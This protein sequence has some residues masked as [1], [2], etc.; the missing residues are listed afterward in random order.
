M[1]AFLIPILL[2]SVSTFAGAQSPDPDC[3]KLEFL[4]G[5][6]K[7]TSVNHI[8]GKTTAGE[9]S[10]KWILG[11]R[12][13]QW[14]FTAQL[15]SG[16]V[17]VLTLINYNKKQAQ[18]AFYSFNPFDDNPLAHFGKWLKPKLLRLEITEDGEKIQIDFKITGNGGFDQIHSKLLPSGERII[19][20][21]TTY[22]KRSSP[23]HFKKKR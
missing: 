7:C 2:V 12:W 16:P 1:K 14:K 20:S 18:Y 13:L 19:R 3:K 6:W 21:A 11:K 10:I 22:S 4:V 17:E 15:D 23:E 5:D 9:S 8:S